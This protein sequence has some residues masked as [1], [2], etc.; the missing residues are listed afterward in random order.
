MF[1][2]IYKYKREK[3]YVY[4][5]D[6]NEFWDG[7]NVPDGYHWEP[8]AIDKYGQHWFFDGNDKNVK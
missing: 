5:E 8:P 4:Y 6:I 1:N 7:E 2:N 3:P